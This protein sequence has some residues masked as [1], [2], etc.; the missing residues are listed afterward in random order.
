MQVCI[1][2]LMIPSIPR[3]LSPLHPQSPPPPSGTSLSVPRRAVEPWAKAVCGD[4]R[5]GLLPRFLLQRLLSPPRPFH[6]RARTPFVTL[7]TRNK[8]ALGASATCRQCQLVPTFVLGS[9]DN[10][11]KLCRNDTRKLDSVS[12]GKELFPIANKSANPTPLP[13]RI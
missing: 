1:S 5:H 7:E 12:V 3:S 2:G 8:T 10:T 13:G 9:G 11:W 4:Q 6:V